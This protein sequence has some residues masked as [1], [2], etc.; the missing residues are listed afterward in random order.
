MQIYVVNRMHN[1]VTMLLQTTNKTSSVVLE[2]AFP[3]TLNVTLNLHL[4]ESD[5]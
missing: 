2:V 1:I 5:F 4:K 3:V